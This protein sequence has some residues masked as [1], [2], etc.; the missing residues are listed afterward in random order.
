MKLSSLHKFKFLCMMSCAMSQYSYSPLPP[1]PDGIRL[2]C[3]RPDENETANIQCDLIPYCL[4]ESG[5]GAHLY[6]ALSYVW[7]ASSKPQSIYV[8]TYELPVTANLYAALSH[9]RD[10]SFE[11]I[12]W[13]DAVCINQED[14][15]EKEHQIQLIAKV[16]CQ[17][18]RV[19]VWLGE[20]ADKSDQAIEEI[21]NIAGK[22]STN[23]SNNEMIQQAILDLLRRPWFRRIWVRSNA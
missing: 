2:L 18:S 15:K 19:I 6:E 21:R 7:G 13:V 14:N 3:L 4:Q 20:A 5:R 8:D 16:Y 22:K 9:L 17:A 23:S 10:R 1:G 11:R 12:I